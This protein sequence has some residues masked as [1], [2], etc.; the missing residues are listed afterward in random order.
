MNFLAHSFLSGKSEDII[1]GN[2]IADFIKGNAF[3][4]NYNSGISKGILLHRLI[5]SF[6]DQD[7]QLAHSRKLLHPF[8]H[9]YSGVVMDIFLDHFLAEKWNE[10]SNLNLSTF[11]QEFFDTL[12]SQQEWMPPI[13]IHL[14][15][16]MKEQDWF[17]NYTHIEG[18][19]L[20]FR[21]FSKRIQHP[22]IENAASYLKENEEQLLETFEEFFPRLQGEVERFLISS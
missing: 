5:D 14:M 17:E 6:T 11:S 10:Y 7:E 20:T 19:D 15:K 2:F 21:R 4:Q 3:R 12:F 18:I 8:F 1:V 9:K 16:T 22:P 13:A